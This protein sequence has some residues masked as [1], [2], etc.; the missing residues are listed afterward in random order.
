MLAGPQDYIDAG[1]CAE[2]GKPI[3]GEPFE[4][5]HPRTCRAQRIHCC[6]PECSTQYSIGW[7]E[8]LLDIN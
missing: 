7:A 6:S 8:S 4:V 2:C 3:E 1:D 5:E